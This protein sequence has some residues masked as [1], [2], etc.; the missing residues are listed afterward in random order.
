MKTLRGIMCIMFLAVCAPLFAQED[1]DIKDA[2]N[3]LYEPI[4]V[5]QRLSYDNFKNIKL[6]T[7][8]IMN[9]GG[10]EADFNRIVDGYA[11]ASALYFSRDYKKAAAEFT[12]NDKDIQDVAMKLSAKYK[13][14]AEALTK[15]IISYSIKSRIRK[16]I[17]GTKTN[18]ADLASEKLLSQATESVAKANDLS[19]RVRP[20]QAIAQYRRAKEQ[21]MVYYETLKVKDVNG[22]K[23]ADRFERDRADVK[24]KIY[25][26]KEKKN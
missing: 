9:Y 17:E 24:N 12:K 19:V 1:P 22:Q 8:A 3:P 6:L 2:S 18:E 25:V 23:L 15:E 16:S 11:E 20:Y 21:C 26:A 4:A 7:V 13:T 10:G 5:V 14:D